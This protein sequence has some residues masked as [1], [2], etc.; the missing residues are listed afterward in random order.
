MPENIHLREA[1]FFCYYLKKAV[2]ESHRMLVEAY[3]EHALSETQCKVW[4]R[5]FRSGDSDVRNAKCGHA[6]KKFKDTELQALL[7]ENNGQTP[8][9]LA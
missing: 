8:Q 1:L 5:K 3:R 7:D 2:A 4:F 9:Q 6:P